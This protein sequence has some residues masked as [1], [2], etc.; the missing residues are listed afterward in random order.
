MAKLMALKPDV[1]GQGRVFL[2]KDGLRHQTIPAKTLAE[3]AA[4]HTEQKALSVAE[5]LSI[6][7]K[8]KEIGLVRARTPVREHGAV[9]QTFQGK[10]GYQGCHTMPCQLVLDNQF[11][12]ALRLGGKL[13]NLTYIHRIV[14][15][16]GRC[17]WQPKIINDIDRAVE[18]R[19]AVDEDGPLQHG[20]VT[21][22]IE[23]VKGVLDG[24]SPLEAFRYYARQ[25]VQYF[26]EA[27]RLAYA[28]PLSMYDATM[29]MA[30]GPQ[31]ALGRAD[32]IRLQTDR[33]TASRF[34]SDYVE[35]VEAI[36]QKDAIVPHIVATG[37]LDK[38]IQAEDWEKPRD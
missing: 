34:Q 8:L 1:P 14:M 16:S 10:G 20:L 3:A 6:T 29:M 7:K 37:E 4:N 9:I 5:A 13:L 23:S 21:D 18:W 28:E 33:H 36:R 27:L 15:L 32:L 2:D 35:V 25:R 30:A 26:D 22:F 12:H 31:G 24:S 19:T 17:T 11:P 38:R